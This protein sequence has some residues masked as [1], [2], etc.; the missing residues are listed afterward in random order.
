MFD[1]YVVGDYNICGRV[2]GCMICLAGS[3][4]KEAVAI[5]EK[6][7]ANPPKNCIGNIRLEKD[8]KENCWWNGNLD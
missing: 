4:E 7:I 1:Y 6:T 8:K 3:D 2:M 5:L